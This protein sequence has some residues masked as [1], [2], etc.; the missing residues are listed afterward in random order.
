MPLFQHPKSGSYFSISNEIP[1]KL[2]GEKISIG[3]NFF[4]ASPAM[5]LLLTFCSWQH[6]SQIISCCEQFSSKLCLKTDRNLCICYNFDLFVSELSKVKINFA[7]ASSVSVE[8]I[9]FFV[10][11]S[12]C[13]YRSVSYL[14]CSWCVYD[15]SY[16]TSLFFC[17]SI[18]LFI[19]AMFKN[20]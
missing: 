20:S 2:M 12:F 3:N 9:D 10:L 5:N 13:H 16:F 1:I 14:K 6:F 4:F 7:V 17:P 8:R 15:I 19:S 11:N 18:F